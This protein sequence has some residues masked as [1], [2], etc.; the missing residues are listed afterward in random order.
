MFMDMSSHI[1]R[2]TNDQDEL[3]PCYKGVHMD[4]LSWGL[5]SAGR[6]W[7]SR[8]TGTSYAGIYPQV[9]HK[10]KMC[11]LRLYDHL[12]QT[13]RHGP[14]VAQLIQDLRVVLQID[15]TGIFSETP[16]WEKDFLWM[17]Q[18]RQHVNNC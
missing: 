17:Q 18:H 12:H 9:Y 13:C 8:R 10:I 15:V 11:S 6:N 16:I 5:L 2:C 1:A 4:R 7:E 3:F 14:P